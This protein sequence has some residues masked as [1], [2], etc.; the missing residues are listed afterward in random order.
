MDSYC[1]WPAFPHYYSFCT[2]AH[3]FISLICIKIYR[4]KCFK[5]ELI[6]SHKNGAKKGDK[7]ETTEATFVFSKA[8]GKETENKT[9]ESRA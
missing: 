7:I 9:L 6:S 8:G 4:K 1:L 5:P 2:K 3:I